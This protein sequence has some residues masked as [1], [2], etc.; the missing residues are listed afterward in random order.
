MHAYDLQTTPVELSTATGDPIKTY[1][2]ATLEIVIPA[3]RRAYK[4]NVICAAVT[5]PIIG[6]D[7]LKSQEIIVRCG[8]SQILDSTTNISAKIKQRSRV[9]NVKII[10]AFPDMPDDIKQLLNKFPSITSPI[11][12]DTHTDNT[13]FHHIDTKSSS[14]TFSRPRRLDE[15]KTKEA[16]EEFETL[17]R[18]G[19]IRPSKSPWSSPLHSVP[20]VDGSRRYV[21]DYRAL[22]SIT[23]PDRYPIPNVNNLSSKLF[24]SSV[25]TKLDLVKAFHQ[26]PI[27]PEDIPKTAVTTPFGLYE[28]VKMPFGLRN[29]SNTFQRYMDSIFAGMDSVF[30]YIDDILLFSKDEESHLRD[31]EEVFRRLDS[32]GLKISP[33]KCIFKVRELDFLGCKISPSGVQPSQSKIEQLKEFPPPTD[34]QSLRRFLGMTGF[35]R[36]LVPDYANIALPLSEKI[37]LFP[38]CKAFELTVEE[39]EAFHRLIS[40]LV[41]LTPLPFPSSEAKNFQLVTDASQFAIGAALHQMI[42]GKSIP[43]GFFSKKLSDAQ[44]KYSTFDRELLAAYFSVLHFKHLIEGRSVL[45][46]T[47]H[48]P[49]VSAFTSKVESKSDRQQRHLS[50]LTEYVTDMAFIKGEDNI[51]ADCLS[52]ACNSVT[53]DVCDLPALAELQSRDS[54]MSDVKDKLTPFKLRENVILQCDNSAKYPRPYVPCES[55]KAIFGEFHN[56]SHSGAKASLKLIKSR[57][58][59]PNMDR[60]IRN[61]CRECLSCQEAKIQRH[62]KLPVQNFHLP[63]PRF[64]TVHVDIVG[65]L[66]PVRNHNDPNGTQ[67]RYMLTMID[68]ATRWIEACPMSDI[69]ASSVAYAFLNT[70]ISRFG[71]PL[72]VVTDRGTQFES[73]LF[74]ELSKLT[75]FH[76]LR[77]TAYHPQTNG[78]IERAHRTLKSA[79]IAKKQTWISALPCILIALR[80]IPTENMSPFCAVTGTNMRVPQVLI[81]SDNNS[82]QFN[83]P[84]IAELA[85]HMSQID[86]DKL[87]TGNIHSASR[88]CYVPS[89]LHTCEFVWLRT[90]R[91]RKAL[92]APYSGPYKVIS[93]FPNYFTIEKPDKS[94]CNVSIERLKPVH[95]KTLS[96]ERSENEQT[97]MQKSDDS[98]SLEEPVSDSSDDSQTGDSVDEPSCSDANKMYYSRS[99]RKIKFNSENVY[100]YY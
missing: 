55:R 95:V 30:C 77:T 10:Q 17:Q 1:G 8:A 45:L 43:I 27:N 63:S 96:K 86:T 75:G 62:T 53:V 9:N 83:E 21:G 39:K 5:Q 23:V 36:K 52:R 97:T 26:I 64:A 2:Q 54:E 14:P 46:L 41:N 91:V 65:P 18:M 68:R 37:K 79:I 67:M 90:D 24:G 22:N 38:K 50:L 29:A 15:K 4:W 98:Q 82:S 40:V 13:I 44:K 72:H 51:V 49:L 25:Y 48:K 76:R 66:P 59:W 28:F 87:A 88:K 6:Y 56:L 89:E 57:Y 34:S 94:T 31:L 3:L 69:T 85:R 73:E 80:S 61:W 100:H 47:D 20:K 74:S 32:H 33:S 16:K 78:M 11:S 58:F 42:D 84:Q 99:G 81:Q 60:D 92:E 71:V 19:I 70:W 12:K 7:F 35:Y 93:R